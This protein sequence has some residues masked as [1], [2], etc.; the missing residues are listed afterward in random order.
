M[1]S[2]ILCGQLLLFE[3]FHFGKPLPLYHPGFQLC[4]LFGFFMSL[5]KRYNRLFRRLKHRFSLLPVLSQFLR[6][7]FLWF[8]RCLWFSFCLYCTLL[9]RPGDKPKSTRGIASTQNSE[10]LAPP[11]PSRMAKRPVLGTGKLSW[12]MKSGWD[13]EG[14]VFH[15][16]SG[17]EVFIFGVRVLLDRMGWLDMWMSYPNAHLFT[18]FIQV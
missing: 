16:L 18:L 9:Q 2:L 17:G 3:L 12:T 5:Q 11:W 1:I 10:T 4:R 7:L 14:T 6:K 13:K 8:W 15:V